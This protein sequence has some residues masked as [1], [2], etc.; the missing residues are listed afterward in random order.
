MSTNG[1]RSRS[2]VY[3]MYTNK[4]SLGIVMS[5]ITNLALELGAEDVHELLGARVMGG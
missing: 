2:S 3:S 4:R 1:K 5:R